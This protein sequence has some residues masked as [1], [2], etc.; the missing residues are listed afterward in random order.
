VDPAV[1]RFPDAEPRF[2]T[3]TCFA[4]EVDPG[5]TVELHPEEHTE[6][7]W[8]GL[9]EAH[10]LMKWEGS[11]AALRALQRKLENSGS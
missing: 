8:C 11:K 9:E 1:V 6:Y 5:Q 3:E 10:A 7:R 2:N 4:L